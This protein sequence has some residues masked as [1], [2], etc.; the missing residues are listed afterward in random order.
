VV[1]VGESIKEESCFKDNPSGAVSFVPVHIVFIGQMGVSKQER[2]EK[3]SW[4]GLIN[5]PMAP[6]LSIFLG[7]CVKCDFTGV[8][9]STEY[10]LFDPD[11]V[12]LN[13]S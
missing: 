7:N 10:H 5:N 11:F 8:T 4:I 2:T 13:F 1:E 9:K 6:E 12:T 3:E